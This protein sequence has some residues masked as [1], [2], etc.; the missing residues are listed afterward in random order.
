MVS[1]S[2]K[3]KKKE[4]LSVLAILLWPFNIPTGVLVRLFLLG[5]ALIYLV[6]PWDKGALS[7]ADDTADS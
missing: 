3:Q 1:K 4:V 2:E 7:A 6:G 5:G